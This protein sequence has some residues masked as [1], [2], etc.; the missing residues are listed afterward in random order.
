[1]DR[2]YAYSGILLTNYIKVGPTELGTYLGTPRNSLKTILIQDNDIKEWLS[3][4]IG[5]I[6]YYR[7][8]TTNKM[9]FMM[10]FSIQTNI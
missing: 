5:D 4:R 10:K 2:H 3:E 8:H 1:M 6:L 9:I 7:G